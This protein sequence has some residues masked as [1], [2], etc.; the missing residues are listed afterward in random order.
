MV[1]LILGSP[2]TMSLK[3]RVAE[4]FTE[5]GPFDLKRL[6]EAELIQI[7]GVSEQSCRNIKILDMFREEKVV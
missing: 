1:G 3:E 4:G 2:M 6:E 5:E 7:V